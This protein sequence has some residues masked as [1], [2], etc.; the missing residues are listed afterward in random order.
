[1]HFGYV[2]KMRDLALSQ[3]IQRWREEMADEEDDTTPRDWINELCEELLRAIRNTPAKPRWAL[4][5]SR[6]SPGWWFYPVVNHQR[7]KGD[8]SMEFEVYMFRLP[9]ALPP[10]VDLP[11]EAA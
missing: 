9:G 10:R 2:A 3:L 4:L 5:R 1:M 6:M 7:I 11:N 8:G